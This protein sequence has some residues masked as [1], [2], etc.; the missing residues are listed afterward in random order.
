MINTSFNFQKIDFDN[1]NHSIIY[2]PNSTGKTRLTNKLAKKYVEEQAMFFTSAQIDDMLSFS[3]RK[4]YVG[5]DS[6]FKLENENIVKEYNK[7]SY[8]AYLLKEYDAKNASELVKNSC[9]FNTIS[10][11]RKDAF[12]IYSKLFDFINGDR[13][14]HT[15]FSFFEMVQIDKAL[16]KLELESI[17]NI[18]SNNINLLIDN[19]DNSITKE[20][21]EKLQSIFDS[22]NSSKRICPLCGHEFETNRELKMAINKMLNSYMISADV[23]DYEICV[24]FLNVLD[25]INA[26]LNINYFETNYDYEISTKLLIDN[27]SIIGDFLI[28]FAAHWHA[29]DPFLE[30]HRWLVD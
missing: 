24:D 28:E 7:S 22:I 13:S 21:K 8:G 19:S 16:S 10:L 15:K 30:Q 27:L 5:S 3:G 29:P 20:L 17:K 1:N 2:A 26:H 4:I 14:H 12:E 25:K 23:H 18:T 6:S 9:L 11:K